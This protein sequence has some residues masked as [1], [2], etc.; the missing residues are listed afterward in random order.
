MGEDTLFECG[1]DGCGMMIKMI[2]MMMMM[3]M[4][5]IKVVMMMMMMMTMRLSHV[6]S[7][8][9]KIWI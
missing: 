1:T 6:C 7:E 8:L 3:M 5:T 2:I 9:S 4:M